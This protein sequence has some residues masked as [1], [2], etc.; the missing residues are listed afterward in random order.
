M[1]GMQDVFLVGSAGGEM[2]CSA[3]SSREGYDDVQ[4]EEND[5]VDRV[6]RNVRKRWERSDFKPNVSSKECAKARGCKGATLIS[7]RQELRVKR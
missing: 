7:A 2:L 3:V 6:V 4:D 1:V 5:T